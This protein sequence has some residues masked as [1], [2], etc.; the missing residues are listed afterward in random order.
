MRFS[1]LIVVLVFLGII[2]ISVH[3]AVWHSNE[4]GTRAENLRQCYWIKKFI[5]QSFK[6]SCDGKGFASQEEW[7]VTCRSMFDLEYIAWCPA[8]EF[9]IVQNDEYRNRLMY[10]TWKGNKDLE[11]CSGEVYY[12]SK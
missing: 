2:G 7:Q 4:L 12:R 8:E 1:T 11:A 5:T 3:Q 6:D 9:M 10:A